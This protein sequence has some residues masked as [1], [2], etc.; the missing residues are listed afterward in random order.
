VIRV[1]TAALL[2]F[3]GAISSAQDAVDDAAGLWNEAT[4]YRDDWGVPHVFAD[5]PRAMAFAFGYAQAEDHLGP[6]LLAY[7]LANGR[8]SEVLGVQAEE[9]DRLAIR[10]DHA[11]L[12][13]RA[14]QIADAVTRDLCE[15]FALGVNTWIM[16]HPDAEP[17]WKDGVQP[18]DVLALLHRYLLGQAP[19]D[20]P[21]APHLVPSTPSANAWAVGPALS[22]TREPMLV[23][24][25]H[26]D[27]E[28]AYQWYEAHLVTRD[29][30][31]YGATLFGLPVIVQGHNGALGWALAPN[32]PD[33][34][35]I[36]VE[37]GEPGTPGDPSS[38]IEA[39]RNGQPGSVPFTEF[40]NR[41]FYTKTADG[42][43][44]NT[45][46]HLATPHG[47]VVGSAEGRLLTWQAGGYRD[48]GALRQLH[49]MGLAQDLDAFRRALDRQQL[50]TFHVVYADAAGNIFYRYNATTGLRV[51]VAAVA[52]DAGFGREGAA[53]D[54]F[55]LPV[56]SLGHQ[57]EWGVALTPDVLPWILNPN[58]GYV[59]ACGT[60]P[61]L[62][63][64][65]A[66][67]EPSAWPAWLIR[68]E[69][70]YR[71][72]RVRRLFSIGPRSFEDMQAMLFD[73]VSPLAAEAVPY[74]IALAEQNPNYVDNAHPDLRVMLDI[75][76]GWNYV[77]ETGS[78]AMTAFHVWWS[79]LRLDEDGKPRPNEIVHRLIQE[80]AAWFREWTLESA[81]EAAQLLRNEYQTLNISWGDVHVIVRGG[82]EYPIAGGHSGDPVSYTG[83]RRFG[84]GKWRVN[85]GYGFAMV[86]RFG[87]TPEAVSL[88]PFGSSENASSP[89]FDDQLPLMLGRRFKVTR[90][91]REDVERHTE[92]ATGRRLLLRPGR[93]SAAVFLSA[94]APMTARL[95]EGTSP[96]AA[97]PEGLAAF[98]TY[99]EPVVEG[100]PAGL[101]V[102]L[103]LRVNE[104]VCDAKD[105]ESL[106]L[107]G[108]HPVDG[109]RQI[110]DQLLDGPRRALTAVMGRCEVIAVL[111]PE[112]AR[113]A[114]PALV[115]L[116]E[117]RRAPEGA[118]L[119]SA[120]PAKNST[121][122]AAQNG[123]A[124][125]TDLDPADEERVATLVPPVPRV[126]T[127]SEDFSQYEPHVPDNIRP[128]A[129]TLVVPAVPP[130]FT[131]E[132]LFPTG[133]VFVP[134]ES[135]PSALFDAQNLGVAPAVQA[136][137]SDAAPA[138]PS[139]EPSPKLSTEDLAPAGAS[140]AEAPTRQPVASSAP[141]PVP[142]P[143]AGAA[144][145]TVKRGVS[146]STKTPAEMLG[147]K[148]PK[149]SQGFDLAPDPARASPLQIGQRL[150]MRTPDG[151][152]V[153]TM[154]TQQDTR[155]QAF[156][157]SAPPAPYPSGLTA[158]SEVYEVMAEPAPASADTA[159]MIRI[160][161]GA[162]A[163]ER[164]GELK[165]Y[166][167]DPVRG[168]QPFAKQRTSPESL[169]FSSMDFSF[170]AMDGGT[171][172]YA[173]LGPADA[174][175]PR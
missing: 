69:D 45:Q 19:F 145:Q 22:K 80:D 21:G 17:A 7:R 41:G 165:L 142:A 120:A 2:V 78:M 53:D 25:P 56:S 168:W 147:A 1:C 50:S 89:H 122:P 13:F 149:A 83:D 86:V 174:V 108:Y 11:G 81:S 166:N 5:N 77:A 26:S 57:F 172:I 48:F 138:A 42:F 60:P 105:F 152:A 43:A 128:G 29:M 102:E 110:E 59:Q 156:L 37:Y 135:R 112:S 16:E 133:P 150:E 35:D 71:A 34:A 28:S 8:A 58:S 85:E 15:G 153:F 100:A 87:E 3:A 64:V 95:K 61:W 9:A 63:T 157:R 143:A 70:T 109:W 118:R 127:P 67:L 93:Q 6:M 103:D 49:D 116:A 144:P 123:D 173:V 74:L 91:A 90:F 66:V 94:G 36:Y 175:R 79:L 72:K 92:S 73:T 76:R 155:A 33:I 125:V 114:D 55:E 170:S 104:T 65:P 31:V 115:R 27:F 44:E 12:A 75:L 107:Y 38:M 130:G 161:P 51:D 113:R 171:R 129:R 54:V 117:T 164:F 141:H 162:V 140:A 32:A 151:A 39:I 62:A 52:S 18:A 137:P 169:S 84:D 136:A 98:T 132:P 154:R 4:L 146:F 99:L 30:N 47:P 46:N 134:E 163:P 14:Y 158:F 88:V 111:G 124:N 96:P 40:E 119:A 160:L 139:Q 126:L 24:N 10:L 131:P 101:S 159:I 82:K 23:I 167:F 20:Y 106:F 68:D 121:L 97:L 148:A